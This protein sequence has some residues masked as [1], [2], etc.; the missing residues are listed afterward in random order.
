VINN[1]SK[2]LRALLGES[3]TLKRDLHENLPAVYIDPGMLDQMLV[4]FAVNSKTP[5]RMGAC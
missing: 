5:C 2:M 1:V 3:I 4:N